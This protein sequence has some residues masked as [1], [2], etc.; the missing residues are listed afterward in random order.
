M[1]VDTGNLALGDR[2]RKQE[3]KV[4]LGY[5]ANSGP[6]W[7]TRDLYKPNKFLEDQGVC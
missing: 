3:F 1:V 5:L 7:V 6:A 4:I 2:G